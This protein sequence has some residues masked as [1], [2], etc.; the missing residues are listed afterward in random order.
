MK[1]DPTQCN[2]HIYECGIVLHVEHMSTVDA[3]AYCD[4]LDKLYPHLD[5]DWYYV[6]GR[7]VFKGIAKSGGGAGT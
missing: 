6:A 2:R 3:E 1:R 7:A 5:V 4:R